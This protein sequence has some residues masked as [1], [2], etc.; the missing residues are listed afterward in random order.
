MRIY[1]NLPTVTFHKYASVLNGECI[2]LVNTEAPTVQNK[3]CRVSS[4]SEM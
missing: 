4:L 2:M 3:G 1:R